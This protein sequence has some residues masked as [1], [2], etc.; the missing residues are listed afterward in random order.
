[1][2]STDPGYSGKHSPTVYSAQD[3]QLVYGCGCGFMKVLGYTT[4]F[5]GV[6]NAEREHRNL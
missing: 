6:M 5:D 1:M 4:N 2:T 3:G